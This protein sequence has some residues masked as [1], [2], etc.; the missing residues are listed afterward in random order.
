MSDDLRERI[1]AIYGD[2]IP[3]SGQFR[4]PACAVNKADVANR[5]REQI[6]HREQ[7]VWPVQLTL[8][9]STL[10]SDNEKHRPMLRGSQAIMVIKRPY[11]EAE[12]RIRGLATSKL[13]SAA[14]A[15]HPVQ[16][17]AK[18][19]V[20]DDRPHDQVNF[21]KLVH[22]S[23]EGVVYNNDRWIYRAVWERAGV[24][25]DQPRAEITITP[26]LP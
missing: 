6:Q 20:P 22:D 5:N 25:V 1:R 8:P 26:L 3:V 21:A 4:T 9:W 10:V 19:W 7:I 17:A 11:A 15:N 18:V 13:G 16:I 2:G 14:P 24:D 23:L 12:K